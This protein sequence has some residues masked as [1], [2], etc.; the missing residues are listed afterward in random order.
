MIQIIDITVEIIDIPVAGLNVRQGSRWG[1]AGL[2][3]ARCATGGWCL[4]LLLVSTLELSTPF[5]KFHN[6]QR[7]TLLGPS[8]C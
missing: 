4:L 2:T 3:L 7:K 5:A 8:S 1:L 6:L